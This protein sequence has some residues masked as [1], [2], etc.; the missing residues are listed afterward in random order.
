MWLEEHLR[1][2]RGYGIHSPFLYRVVRE[3]MMPQRVKGGD[4]ALYEA[5]RA[6]GVGSRAATRAQNL[7]NAMGYTSWSI[8][9]PNGNDRG[10]AVATQACEPQ[11]IAAMVEGLNERSGAVCVIHRLG[12]KKRRAIC[13]SLI[14]RHHCLSASKPTMK[15]YFSQQGVSKQHVVI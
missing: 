10:L 14:G 12:D 7:L 5:L 9:E 6:K 15:L 13:K 11:T 2:S 3:A 1:H 8:D 4:K